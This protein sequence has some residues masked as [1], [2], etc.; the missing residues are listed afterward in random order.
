MGGAVYMGDPVC[1]WLILTD[2][3]V[4]AAAAA[5]PGSCT[6]QFKELIT[7][8]LGRLSCTCFR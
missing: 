1:E 8:A 6:T 5:A 2:G 7:S 3:E 4:L